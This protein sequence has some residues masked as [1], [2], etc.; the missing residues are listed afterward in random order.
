MQLLNRQR[1]ICNGMA[2]CDFVEVWPTLERAE[3]RSDALLAKL[4]SPKLFEF[5]DRIA[6]IVV[7]QQRKVVVF[8]QWRRML[9]LAGWATADVLGSAGLS[10]A[11]FAGEETQRRRTETL[12]RS[13]TIPTL[14]CCSR[15]ML[16]VLG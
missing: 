11:F 8:S 15:P 14:A 4:D 7:T 5:R 1:M 3:P 9:R 2:L 16:A 6:D 10:A 13:M 12:L